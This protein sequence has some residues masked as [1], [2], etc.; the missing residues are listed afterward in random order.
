[1]YYLT[2]EELGLTMDS[3]VDGIHA[4]DLGMQQY[5]NAYATKIAAILSF[6]KYQPPLYLAAS[7]ANRILMNG[8]KDTK[9]SY[10]ITRK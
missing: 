10:P 7:D 2:Y 8:T 6:A 4:T 5:A 3:Q 9:P 1:M